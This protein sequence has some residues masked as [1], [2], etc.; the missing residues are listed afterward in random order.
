ML[1][2]GESSNALNALTCASFHTSCKYN[3]CGILHK[4]TYFKGNLRWRVKRKTFQY[5]FLENHLMQKGLPKIDIAC[6]DEK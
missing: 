2:Y 6:G 3:L 4:L 1:E 5:K